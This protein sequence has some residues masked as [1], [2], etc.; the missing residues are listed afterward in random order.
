MKLIVNINGGSKMKGFK[1][2]ENIKDVVVVEVE[3]MNKVELIELCKGYEE[4]LCFLEDVRIGRN[5]KL[6]KEGQI[7]RIMNIFNEDRKKLWSN[8][9]LAKELSKGWD[10]PVSSRNVASL[11]SYCR[12]G[13]W[14]GGVVVFVS[15]SAGRVDKKRIFS[16]DGVEV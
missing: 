7:D 11:L 14:Q 16:I 13:K 3:K 5:V 8:G 2:N 12:N 6:K 10:K 9:E 15:F 4:V 1:M